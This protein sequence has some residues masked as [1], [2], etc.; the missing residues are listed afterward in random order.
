[1]SVMSGKDLPRDGRDLEGD[2]LHRRLERTWGTPPGLWAWISTVDH[3]LIS[4][5]YIVTALIFMLL[6][7]ILS[8]VMR[9]QLAGPES[10]LITPTAT[11]SSSPCTE[12][13]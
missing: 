12:R 13:R 4:R 8:L 2:A 5:R 3:K 6:G 11:T 9:V 7:G 10:G 1:M